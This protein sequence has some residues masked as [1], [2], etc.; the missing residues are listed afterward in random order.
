MAAQ[1]AQSFCR[2]PRGRKSLGPIAGPCLPSRERDQADLTAEPNGNGNGNGEQ[3]GSASIVENGPA[4]AE[5]LSK[6]SN[7]ITI[8]EVVAS[9]IGTAITALVESETTNC[10]S[11]FIDRQ[12]RHHPE[13]KDEGKTLAKRVYELE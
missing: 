3:N 5:H 1:G 8:T 4:T 7:T 13:D 11:C 10:G 2:S 9:F 12:I 6:R